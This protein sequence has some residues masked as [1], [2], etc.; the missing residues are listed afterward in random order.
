MAL[1]RA[2]FIAGDATLGADI[3]RTVRQTLSRKRDPAKIA[4]ETRAMRALI[5]KEKGDRDAWDLKL[6]AGGLIDIEFIAQSLELAFAHKH[7]DILDVS[8]R[9][10]VE[11]AGR[12]RLIAP[13]QAEALVDAHRL[14]TDTTQFMR[15]STSG[16]FD[17]AKTAGGVKRR[18]AGASGFPDFEALAAALGEARKRVRATFE[19]ILMG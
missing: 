14:Y 15:L 6:A 19:T 3:A 13:E 16:P 8:T 18:I 17:P 4:R 10:V 7:P 5:A 2:R 1:T 12:E 9:K 11:E